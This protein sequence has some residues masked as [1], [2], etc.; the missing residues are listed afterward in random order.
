MDI[1]I[2]YR[3]EDCMEG[4][5]ATTF[6]PRTTAV[7]LSKST[8]K[9]AS[10]NQ[11]NVEALIKSGQV[12]V[13]GCHAISKSVAATAQANLD[14]SMSTWTALVSVKSLREALDLR[15]SLAHASLEAAFAE[16]GKFTDASL[17]LAGETMAPLTER[18]TVAVE[19]FTHPTD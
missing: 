3:G 10:F 1:G 2:N 19:K 6:D 9:M 12:W 13:A 4:S 17:K 18:L 5:S 15:S 14:K 11:G 8:E 16:T 7:N